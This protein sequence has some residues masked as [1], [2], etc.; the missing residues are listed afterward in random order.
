M[1]GQ[2]L[3]AVIGTV[4]FSVLYSVPRE[5]YPYCGFIGGGG[6]LVYCLFIPHASAPE[7]TFIA[8]ILVVLLSR[9]CA[10][11]ERCPV[12]IFLISG[13][14]PLVPGGGVYWAA[15]YIVT[16]QMDLAAKTGFMALKVAVAVVLGIVIVFQIPQ[17]AFKMKRR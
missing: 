4:A 10:V 15:Y 1:I 17:S 3:A 7:A 12:T 8:A 13:I 11:W 14:F 2:V 5:Y 16:A 9:I 6:W